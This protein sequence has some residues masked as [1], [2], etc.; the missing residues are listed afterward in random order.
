LESCQEAADHNSE[1]DKHTCKSW[2]LAPD[3]E[4][5]AR[6]LLRDTLGSEALRYGLVKPEK[7]AKPRRR[8]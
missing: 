1:L 7:S 3:Y 5:E 6:K 4:L 2:L 8:R